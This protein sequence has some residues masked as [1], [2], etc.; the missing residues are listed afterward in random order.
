[1]GLILNNATVKAH[2]VNQ[3]MLTYVPAI[4]RNLLTL[5]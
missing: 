3:W 5:Y 2:F 1:M 4:V